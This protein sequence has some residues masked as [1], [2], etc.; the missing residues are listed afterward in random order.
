ME[1]PV[2]KGQKQ[3]QQRYS[4]VIALLDVER[5]YKRAYLRRFLN[6]IFY[7]DWTSLNMAYKGIV[8]SD[9]IDK[10]KDKKLLRKILE[11]ILCVQVREPLSKGR[12]RYFEL[13]EV[14]IT[15][16]HGEKDDR[17]R[18]LINVFNKKKPTMLKIGVVSYLCDIGVINEPKGLK[19][20]LSQKKMSALKSEKLVSRVKRDIEMLEIKKPNRAIAKRI[21]LYRSGSHYKSNI[22]V[23]DRNVHENKTC[24][25]L[26]ANVFKILSE[27]IEPSK[28]KGE[29]YTI[30][31]S[32]LFKLYG[33]SSFKKYDSQN[34]F[35][36]A[37]RVSTSRFNRRVFPDKS[38]TLVSTMR[39]FKV[40]AKQLEC[41]KIE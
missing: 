39:Y 22:W 6:L 34:A 2:R 29:I 5:N 7:E 4:I 9:Y 23:S 27:N 38:K 35:L 15:K 41:N 12:E 37:L 21:V 3:R 1:N 17:Y 19:D 25:R 30:G 32:K 24:P 14:L 40:Y 26:L 36:S 28:K 8:R 18:K 31:M 13:V 20:M 33:S 10:T 16:L 11:L